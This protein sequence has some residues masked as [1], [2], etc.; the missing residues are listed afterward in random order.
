MCVCGVNALCKSMCVLWRCSATVRH[1]LMNVAQATLCEYV[2][3]TFIAECA[4]LCPDVIQCGCL[5]VLDCAP[6]LFNVAECA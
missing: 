4:W 3:A 1:K 2:E 5:S 6:M